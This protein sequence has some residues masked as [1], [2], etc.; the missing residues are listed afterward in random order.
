MDKLKALLQKLGIELTADQSRQID[1]VKG[2]AHI[3]DIISTESYRYKSRQNCTARR[4]S[5]RQCGLG[6]Y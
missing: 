1:E 2:L 4:I 6:L 3:S 5:H